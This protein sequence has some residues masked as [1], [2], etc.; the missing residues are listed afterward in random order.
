LSI[1]TANITAF[2]EPLSPASAEELEKALAEKRIE[3]VTELLM[4]DF[5][6]A[7]RKD[8]VDGPGSRT[9]RIERNGA[10]AIVAI[11]LNDA[12]T[13][14]KRDANDLSRSSYRSLYAALIG[15]GL[16][17]LTA[18]LGGLWLLRRASRNQ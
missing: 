9:F 3:G 14:D 6:T 10:D 5:S 2:A 13:G 4:H 12:V 8:D 15:G 18:I 17:A 16:L 1:P 7:V 11:T